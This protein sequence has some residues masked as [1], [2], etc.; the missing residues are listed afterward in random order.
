MKLKQEEYKDL[1]N[2]K[3]EYITHIPILRKREYGTGKKDDKGRPLPNWKLLIHSD[4]KGFDKRHKESNGRYKMKVVLPKHTILIRYGPEAGSFTAPK[5]TPYEQL[6]LPYTKE[7]VFYHEYEVIAESIT[8]TAI[9]TGC[10][11][12]RGKAAPGFDYPGGGVQY[13][14]PH[15]MIAA[16]NLQLLKEITD[17]KIENKNTSETDE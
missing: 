8:V 11:V 9:N 5:G 17:V 1:V 2:Y 7:S 14:H 13:L 6:S 16:R 4:N 10:I 15:S 3:G 12:T